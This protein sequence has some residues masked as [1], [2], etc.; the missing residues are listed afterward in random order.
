MIKDIIDKAIAEGLII[1][2]TDFS[3]KF[4]KKKVEEI[5]NQA[6][7]SIKAE[8][9]GKLPPRKINRIENNTEIV[10]EDYELGFNDCLSSIQKII[11]EACK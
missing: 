9:L 5:I 1:S 2:H 8:L 6:L 11:N 4:K 7:A 10:D 3:V